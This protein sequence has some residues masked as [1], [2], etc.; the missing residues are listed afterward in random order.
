[1]ST[2]GTRK[3]GV[4]GN[5][6]LGKE[7]WKRRGKRRRKVTG[8]KR[9]SKTILQG[10]EEIGRVKCHAYTHTRTYVHV[11]ICTVR[12][13]VGGARARRGGGRLSLLKLNWREAQ[14]WKRSLDETKLRNLPQAAYKTHACVRVCPAVSYRCNED[15]FLVTQSVREGGRE[16]ERDEKGGKESGDQLFAS[17]RS[18]TFLR[19]NARTRFLLFHGGLLGFLDLWTN[20][21]LVSFFAILL[22]F[23]RWD[24]NL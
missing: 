15:R 19:R 16:R 1:M 3:G 21:C 10:S 7:E 9:S 5:A 23:I 18:Q 4:R 11:Y 8:K 17:Q 24:K 22:Q 13:N 14:P 20:N 6:A 12:L 2:D